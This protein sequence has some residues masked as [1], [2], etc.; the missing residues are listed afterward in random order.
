MSD[1]FNRT[2]NPL[3]S[4]GLL[5]DPL[6][7]YYSS[8]GMI[9]NHKINYTYLLVNLIIAVIVIGII[10]C[11]LVWRKRHRDK[12]LKNETHLYRH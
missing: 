11:F 6:L 4:K 10:T 9:F 5:M 1:I 8:G 12:E 3:N 7:Y 2:V